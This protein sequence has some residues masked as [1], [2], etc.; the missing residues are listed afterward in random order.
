VGQ[1]RLVLALQP[2]RIQEA[3]KISA[4][5][6]EQF[7]LKSLGHIKTRNNSTYNS[8]ELLPFEALLELLK[9]EMTL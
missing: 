7:Q 2:P 5:V 6:E 3:A 8:V 4:F 9:C 1:I